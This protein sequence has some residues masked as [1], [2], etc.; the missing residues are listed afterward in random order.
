M[1]TAVDSRS[2]AYLRLA[3]GDPDHADTAL[4]IV[5]DT[6]AEN[7]HVAGLV[8]YGAAQLSTQ[9]DYG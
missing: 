4:L 2:V 5:R 9:I 6:A 3:V 8:A 7:A 1:L